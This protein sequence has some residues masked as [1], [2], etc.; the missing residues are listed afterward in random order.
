MSVIS[1]VALTF[2][3]LHPVSFFRQRTSTF[4]SKMPTTGRKNSWTNKPV[5]TL[6][7]MNLIDSIICL[8][9]SKFMS[10][11][12]FKKNF[13]DSNRNIGNQVSIGFHCVIVQISC[14]TFCIEKIDDLNIL[15]NFQHC[16]L[17]ITIVRLKAL[18]LD[19][20]TDKYFT[21]KSFAY[22]RKP[23]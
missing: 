2:Q 5:F 1:F 12:T 4:A 11:D 9:A 19:V 17:P 20:M 15:V 16:C 14:V 3:A 7:T 13:I 23:E 6:D 21:K 8:K 10:V 22:L 18:I